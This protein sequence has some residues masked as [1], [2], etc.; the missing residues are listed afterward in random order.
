MDRDVL[1]TKLASLSRCIGRVQEKYPEFAGDLASDYDRQDIIAVNL[2]HG[3]QLAV[4]IGT[5]LVAASTQP[6]P[7]T[8]AQVFRLL[9]QQSVI[10]PSLGEAL[11]KAAGLRNIA[12]HEYS[13]LDWERLHEYL[14]GAL[15]D[16][17]SFAAQVSSYGLQAE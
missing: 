5:H 10:E 16:L 9:A 17:R 6:V 4:D 14:P 8:M 13:Q 2:E 11:A 1:Q 12:V 7:D 3:I 15:A